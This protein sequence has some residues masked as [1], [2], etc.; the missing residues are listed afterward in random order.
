MPG[1]RFRRAAGDMK[2]RPMHFSFTE[3]LGFGV[4]MA[5]WLVWGSGQI[6]SMLVAPAKGNIEALR[7][8]PLEQAPAADGEEIQEISLATLLT[9]ADPVR[10]AKVFKKC[11]ACHTVESGGANKVGPN[12]WAVIGRA[13]AQVPGFAYSSALSG[14]TK[15]WTYENLAEFL[16]GPKAYAP[17]NKMTFKGLSKASDRAAVIAYLRENHDSPPPLP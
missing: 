15:A 12:L 4:L 1:W 2:G 10:G 14:V 17:G 13:P 9:L 11:A 16:A 7:I 6:S 5:A 8:A 3:K